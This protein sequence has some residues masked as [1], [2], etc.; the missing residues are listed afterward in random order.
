[1]LAYLDL[2]YSYEEGGYFIL[3]GKER[4]IIPQ[5]NL[6]KNTLFITIEDGEVTGTLHACLESVDAPRVVNKFIMG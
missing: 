5:K 4:I 1:V 3:R 6:G 2:F